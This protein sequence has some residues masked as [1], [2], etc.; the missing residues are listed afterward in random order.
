MLIVPKGGLCNRL[1]VLFSYYLIAQQKKEELN[2]VWNST[3]E[4][5]G[6]FLDYFKPIVGVTFLNKLPD[7]SN[8]FYSGCYPDKQYPPIY[9]NLIVV[10]E[11]KNLLEKNKKILKEYIAIH[12]RR[13]DHIALAK[14]KKTYTENAEFFSFIKSN[15]ADR[16]LYIATDNIDTY[17]VFKEKYFQQI[18]LSYHEVL[19]G[20]RKTSLKDAII[21]LYMCVS[22]KNFMGS[23]YSS[24]SELIETLR[25]G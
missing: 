17:N 19:K 6:L 12:V 10:D 11:I 14:R 21:D 8:V 16:S 25:K 2:V 9:K 24:F 22:A 3:S 4:C 13:T 7:E 5:P 20:F 15:I 18:K 23:R 1:R